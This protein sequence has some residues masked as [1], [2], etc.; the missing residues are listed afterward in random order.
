MYIQVNLDPLEITAS[1]TYLG[2]TV[3]LNNSYWA[4][5]YKNLGKAHRRWE[6]V[7]KLLTK[8]GAKVRSRLMMY[9][10]EVHTVPI[11]GRESWIIME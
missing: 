10:A 4:D 5:L 3:N 11:Y 6:M 8:M 7:A 2:H 1:F 9:K